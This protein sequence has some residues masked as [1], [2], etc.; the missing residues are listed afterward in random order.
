MTESYRVIAVQEEGSEVCL[1]S[2]MSED[3]A[4]ESLPEFREMHEEYRSFSVEM[5]CQYSRDYED[6]WWSEWE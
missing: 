2:G 3:Q 4:Y 5:E 6:Q 1:A